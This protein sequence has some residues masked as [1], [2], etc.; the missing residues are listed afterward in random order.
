MDMLVEEPPGEKE[1]EGPGGT[2]LAVA[3]ILAWLVRHRMETGRW[4]TRWSGRLPG[5]N[6]YQTWHAI[7]LALRLGLRGLPGGQS[8]AG[9]IGEQ[10]A[11]LR[12]MAKDHA[13]MQG[14][15]GTRVQGDRSEPRP[16]LDVATILAWADQH[17]ART[18]RWPGTHSGLVAGVLGENWCSIARA[19]IMGWRG[20]P[21]GTTLKRLLVEHRGPDVLNRIRELTVERILRWADAYHR[22]N[23]VW[24]DSASGPVAGVWRLTWSSVDKF[25][26][27]GGRGLP[28]GTS[29]ARLLREQRGP[30]RWQKLPALS[31]EQILAWADAHHAAHGKWPK[32]SPMPIA[33]APGESW[34]RI[35]HALRHGFRGLPGGSSLPRLLEEHR[36]ILRRTLSLEMVLA[37]SRAHHAATGRW[38]VAGSGAIAGAPG[39]TWSK[40]DAALRTGC[41]GLPGGSS[42]AR[43]LRTVDPDRSRGRR[44]LTVAQVLA[45]ADA[46]H[47]A[48]GRWPN[49]NSGAVLGAPGEKWGNLHEALKKGLRGLPPGEGLVSLLAG[50]QAPEAVPP[51]GGEAAKGHGCAGSQM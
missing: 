50:R 32:V 48:T 31:V 46:H 40:I 30:C 25:L 14:Q 41:R 3:Q 35:D 17:R 38:P 11:L 7:D 10:G 13:R 33:A 22:A 42:L 44:P 21:G 37:W 39:E 43:L 36:G 16:P 34:K 29:L 12:A 4:P 51:E 24:P 6:G 8:L 1:P 27:D 20:L 2:G 45:W 47:A 5:E 9:L 18:G 19:L 49:T 23:G 26:K 15:T 28:G